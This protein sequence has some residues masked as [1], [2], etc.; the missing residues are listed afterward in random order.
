[1][2]KLL[3]LSLVT[4][5]FGV[6]SSWVF[7]ED[8]PQWRGPQRNGISKETGLLKEW[9]KDGPKL[10]WSVSDLGTGY[11][12]P[13]VADGRLYVIANAGTETESVQALDANTGKRLWSTQIGKVGTNRGPQYP[14][15]RSTPTVDGDR[16]YALGSDGD[17]ACLDTSTGN[18]AWQKN[19]KAEFSGTPGNWAYAE[20]PLVDGDVL[21]CTPGGSKAT[22]VALNKTT[23]EPIWKCA[24]P[25]ADEAAYASA[26]VL[27]A[28]GV[29]QYVQFLQRGIVG[30]D[31][32]TGRFLWRY[33]RTAQGS[34]ANIPTPITDKGHVYS[35]TRSGGALV[36]V[37]KQG[38]EF[39]PTELYFSPKL[40]NS[41]G[42]AVKV[43]E[44]LYG[45]TGQALVC[46][47]FLTGAIRWEERNPLAPG[48]VCYADGRLYLHGESSGQVAL[49]EVSPEG[50]QEK[51]R[52]TPK[53]VPAHDGRQPKAWAY[54]VVANGKLYIRDLHSLW[55]YDIRA[56]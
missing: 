46:A 49:L 31:A 2:K 3:I 10:L 45:T 50:F 15:S 56:Q 44:H 5:A 39:Q 9:P 4:V 32:A 43:G 42:G 30:V 16:L 12:T 41:I 28:D 7:S 53:D 54:P 13:S 38:D 29:K 25:G 14:G 27:D 48:S 23:G 47:D 36:K 55:C 33:D 26:V 20:S 1:M 17:L 11:S 51:G 24:V 22:V 37:S 35:A 21:V 34:P 18:I 8:W 40:P 19:L 52:F 6:N